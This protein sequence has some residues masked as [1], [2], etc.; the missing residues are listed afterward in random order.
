MTGPWRWETAWWNRRTGE[1]EWAA[2]GSYEAAMAHGRQ[3]K[4]DRH[5]GV[6]VQKVN[7]E[8][9]QIWGRVEL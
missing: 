7:P 3:L 8:T 1:A 5:V 2:H 9:E 4:A 6:V